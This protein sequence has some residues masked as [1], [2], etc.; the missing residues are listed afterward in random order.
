MAL[1]R[2]HL[3]SMVSLLV[4]VAFFERCDHPAKHI[5]N[6]FYGVDG[7]S[8]LTDVPLFPRQ[9]YSCDSVTFYFTK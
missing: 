4:C 5:C 3:F 6:L 9:L 2:R 1:E 7:F 8:E